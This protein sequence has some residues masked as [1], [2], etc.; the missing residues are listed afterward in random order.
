MPLS[1]SLIQFLRDA[2]AGLG[3]FAPKYATPLRAF[4]SMH[5]EPEKIQSI[6]DRGLT[7]DVAKA[8]LETI[9]TEDELLSKCCGDGEHLAHALDLLFFTRLPASAYLDLTL[10]PGFPPNPFDLGIEQ[11]EQSLYGQGVFT[12]TAYFHLYNFWARPED[13]PIAPYP[14]WGFVEL[15]HSSIPQLLGESSFSSFLSPSMTGRY[16]LT[17]QDSEGFNRESVNDWLNRRWVNIAPYRQV[18][19]YSKDAVIDIDYATPYFNPPWVNQIHRGGLYY[20]GAPRQDVLPATFWYHMIPFDSETIQSNWLCYQKY[21]DR[22]KPH[23]SSLRKAIRIAGNF[24]EECHKKVSR[25][26]Q[27]ANLMIALEALYTPSD[28]SEHTFR[29]SQNCALLI[30]NSAES[31]E[32][33][34][35]FLRAMFK[36][37]GKLFHGQYDASAQSPQDFITDE[38]LKS[39]MSIVRRSVLKFLALFLRGEDGL[40]K[41]RKDLEKAVLDETFRTEFLEKADF[42][43]LSTRETS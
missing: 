41:V 27:F 33:T 32:H 30:E 38:E 5:D 10:A 20:W 22:I 6:I 24:F 16:F 26:E 17:V 37:R 2:V 13:L 28:A 21:A 12:K 25:I 11:L 43:S 39:L 7:I 31:R 9:L 35:E 3:D 42:E 23:G 4:L 15:E 18:L 29:I 8:K 36:R 1:E 34:F 14:G 19:Q 40:D